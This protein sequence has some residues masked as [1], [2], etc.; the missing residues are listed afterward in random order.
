MW[1]KIVEGNYLDILK[2]R[3]QTSL[4]TVGKN[5]EKIYLFGGEYRNADGYHSFLSDFYELT[6]TLLKKN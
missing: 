1:R 6:V 5:N 2:P 3:Y 4:C